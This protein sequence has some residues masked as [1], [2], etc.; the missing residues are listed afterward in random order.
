MTF[1]SKS[2]FNS[3]THDFYNIAVASPSNSGVVGVTGN[4]ID[5]SSS[6]GILIIVYPLM[7][8]SNVH[9]HFVKYT[10]MPQ[11]LMYTT[12]IGLPADEYKVV[13]FV[14]EEDG[15]PFCRAAATPRTI[16]INGKSVLLQHSTCI[17]GFKA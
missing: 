4:I 7:N 17:L 15:T 2:F 9:Y 5:G 3:G 1:H 8:D 11:P 16:Q 13:V 12:I 6:I 10:D 14:M